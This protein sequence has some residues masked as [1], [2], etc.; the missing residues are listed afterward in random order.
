MGNANTISIAPKGFLPAGAKPRN[1][2]MN[3]RK[4]RPK[5][6]RRKNFGYNV[7]SKKQTTPQREKAKAKRIEDKENRFNRRN[8]TTIMEQEFKD[9]KNNPNRDIARREER[10]RKKETK[11]ER[12]KKRKVMENLD[13][14]LDANNLHLKF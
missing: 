5:T 9:R 3:P 10:E 12:K 14:Y 11:E 1:K 7:P 4:T 8:F 6:P 2:K 13:K